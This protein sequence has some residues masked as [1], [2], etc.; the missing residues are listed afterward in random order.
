MK[1]NKQIKI[2]AFSFF[3]FV[4]VCLII[5][6]SQQKKYE[7]LIKDG[8]YTIGIGKDVDKNRR[9][10]RKTFTFKYKVSNKVYEGKH[11]LTGN[12]S[13]MTVGGIYFVVF[14]PDKPRKNFLIKYP[15]VP[16]EINLDNIP[17]EGWSELPVPVPKDSI[18]NFL[19]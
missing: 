13:E 6:F 4:A 1:I 8:K 17:P 2:F 14:D 12:E 3:G 16:A 5:Y 19:D 15:A 11:S 10:G 7:S 9:V 18:R